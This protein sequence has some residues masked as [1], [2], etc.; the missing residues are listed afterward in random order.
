M[1][2]L[3]YDIGTGNSRVSIVS[4]QKEMIGLRTFENRYYR[5]FRYKDALYFK[6]EEMLL[7]VM[8]CTGELLK[9]H[10]EVRIEAVTATSARE[11][12][13]LI[14]REGHWFYGLPN[15]DNRGEEWMD[16]IPGKDEVYRKTGRW[17]STVFSAGKLM[18]LKK[19]YPDIYT[20]IEGITS[21]SGWIGYVFTGELVMEYS[22]ACETQLF[23]IGKREWDEK[24]CALFG[25]NPGIL[26]RVC[27]AS[28]SLGRV[29]GSLC[30]E[31]GLQKETVFTAG[32]ADTQAA[33]YGTDACEKEIVIVSG[34]TSPVVTIVP[35]RFYDAAKRCWVDCYLDGRSYQIETNAGVSGMNYQIL[36]RIFFED[37]DYSV[38]DQKMR[39]KSRIM[40]VASLGTLIFSENKT[41][42]NGGFFMAAPL[43]E[44]MD[45]YDFAFALAADIACGIVT[46]YHSLCGIIPCERSYILGCG[47]GFQSEMLCQLIADL[48]QKTLIIRSSYR[49]ASVIGC[50]KLCNDYF[51][52]KNDKSPEKRVYHPRENRMIEEYFDRWTAVRTRIN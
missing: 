50:V 7:E 11:S 14:D 20:R 2:Y 23:D 51:G 22:Q 10:P 45:R 12:I 17:V 5:D 41:L 26:P 27:A 1:A 19:R 33:V 49:Q 43:D 44:E 4:E 13:V 42:K 3:I 30:E 9:A 24:L 6:P 40:C 29:K 28:V 8:R 35:E 32:G 52:R 34:T 18:G 48:A 16:A 46:Q 21:L 36:K 31:L 38:L 15:I 39:E 25:I 37:V 47:G